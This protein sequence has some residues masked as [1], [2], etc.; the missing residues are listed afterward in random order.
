MNRV[1]WDVR[2]SSGLT[3]PPGAYQARLKVG[4]VTQ[5]QPFTVL[6]DPRIAAEGVT[7]ADL[8][9]QF[10]HNMR[11]RELSAELNQLLA[12]VRAAA[13]GTDRREADRAREI[14]DADRATCPRTSVTTSPAC[15]RTS[16][17]WRA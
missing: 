1:V 3:M 7:V 9:E 5:T 13:S 17:T 8:K 12:R 15:R 10:D 11:M 6:I 4:D 2:H 16:D 14:Y